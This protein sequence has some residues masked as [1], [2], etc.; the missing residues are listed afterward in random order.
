MNTYQR[1]K[2]NTINMTLHG[3]VDALLIFKQLLEV[4]TAFDVPRDY[5]DDGFPHL[6]IDAHHGQECKCCKYTRGMPDLIKVLTHGEYMQRKHSLRF[7][8]RISCIK[9]FTF[10]GLDS[11]GC[12]GNK[13]S[14]VRYDM[15]EENDLDITELTPTPGRGWKFHLLYEREKYDDAD[16]YQPGA[17]NGLPLIT[18][19]VEI[20][21]DY[22]DRIRYTLR[23]IFPNIPEDKNFMKREITNLDE[24]VWLTLK[25]MRLLPMTW[26]LQYDW[27]NAFVTLKALLLYSSFLD[28]L[29]HKQ[30]YTRNRVFLGLCETNRPII[31]VSDEPVPD[32][33]DSQAVFFHSLE[34]GASEGSTRWRTNRSKYDGYTESLADH[35]E[36]FWEDSIFFPDDSIPVNL[37]RIGVSPFRVVFAFP[38]MGKTTATKMYPDQF[39]DL[40]SY[41][42][43]RDIMRDHPEYDEER[44]CTAVVRSLRKSVEEACWA[45]KI[46]LL[47][48]PNDFD[49]IGDFIGFFSNSL[50]LLPSLS[51]E[52]MVTRIRE[53]G[54]NDFAQVYEENYH[55]WISHWQDISARRCVLLRYGRTV[56]G[57]LISDLDNSTMEQTMGLFD[58]TMSPFYGTRYGVARPLNDRIAENFEGYRMEYLR[59]DSLALTASTH[60]RLAAVPNVLDSFSECY[61]E[62]D[63]Y[64]EPGSYISRFEEPHVYNIH[65]RLV[66]CHVDDAWGG[67][68]TMILKCCRCGI[69]RHL[70]HHSDDVIGTLSG[71][72]L[73][74]RKSED[75][76]TFFEDMLDRAG[77]YYDPQFSDDD[78]YDTDD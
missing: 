36:S 52:E 13:L 26:K 17:R 5:T 53:R 60:L 70:C 39:V 74:T 76:I 6:Q 12:H 55:S 72:S 38:G 57:S 15:I 65:G 67:F 19:D 23:D 16:D 25:Y 29:G 1:G 11:L 51:K 63:D 37:P 22:M 48:N 54:D 24:M 41:F 4:S 43:R 7:Y 44:V 46:P 27:P 68:F 56:T 9:C 18:A 78:Y 42:I 21:N 61:P 62:D 20:R 71:L 2:F 3:S 31:H 32:A 64:L 33:I 45:K 35:S 59:D 50:I 66:R 8:D 49:L 77:N 28:I 58:L 30:V 73:L 40:D 14:P 34:V 47:N 10:D 75:D 69:P